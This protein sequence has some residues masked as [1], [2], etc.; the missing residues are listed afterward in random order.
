MWEPTLSPPLP[1]PTTAGSSCSLPCEVFMV[2]SGFKIT[3]RSLETN[4]MSSGVSE[5]L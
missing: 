3:L 5:P 2:M 4:S 1:T